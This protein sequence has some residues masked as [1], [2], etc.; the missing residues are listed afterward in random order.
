MVDPEQPGQLL[1]VLLG[2]FQFRDDIELPVYQA[3]AAPGHRGQHRVHARTE[4]GL[5][6]GLSYRL[7]EHG[8]ERP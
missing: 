5:L 2:A 1:R 8:I 4:H 6:G 3:L 7:P